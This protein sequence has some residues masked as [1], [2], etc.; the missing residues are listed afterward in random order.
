MSEG[1]KYQIEGV[2]DEVGTVLYA[3]LIPGTY[4][5]GYYIQTE[6]APANPE[7]DLPARTY[8]YLSVGTEQYRVNITKNETFCKILAERHPVMGAHITVLCRPMIFNSRLFYTN[9][10]LIELEGT[11][12]GPDTVSL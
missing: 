2:A 4:L 8:V 9:P 5:S 10:E 7:R 3:S 1:K 12:F 6:H 11:N